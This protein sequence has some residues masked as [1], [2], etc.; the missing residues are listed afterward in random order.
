MCHL[1]R[2][3]FQETGATRTLTLF[4]GGKTLSVEVEFSRGGQKSIFNDGLDGAWTIRIRR[5]LQESELA[6]LNPGVEIVLT[7]ERLDNKTERFFYKDGIEEF[8]RQR[9]GLLIGHLFTHIEILTDQLEAFIQ[10]QVDAGTLPANRLDGLGT[11][12]T[13]W[14]NEVLRSTV[15]QNHNIAFSGGTSTTTGCE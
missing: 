5:E 8:V 12:N 11:A 13:N 3:V 6:F 4:Y 10:E 15:S 7:D 9:G 14:E 1:L 2:E